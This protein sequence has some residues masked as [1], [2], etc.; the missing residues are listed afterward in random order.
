MRFVAVWPNGVCLFRR[1]SPLVRRSGGG[2]RGRISGFS[3]ASRRRLRQ[4]LLSRLDPRAAGERRLLWI[5][6]TS[7]EGD[8]LLLKSRLRACFEAVRRLNVP[9]GIVWRLE[10]QRRG[11]AHFH[12]LVQ[13]QS[14]GAALLAARTLV[15]T[16]LRRCGDSASPAAQCV[17]FVRDAVGLSLYVSDM[18][19]LS[20]SNPGSDSPGRFWGLRGDFFFEVGPPGLRRL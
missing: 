17:K 13:A 14:T 10:Y 19:K 2:R 20:Q 11:V 1:A 15:V 16:W 6:L 12:L 9:V 4:T 7:R 5:T 8:T 18:S 3:S